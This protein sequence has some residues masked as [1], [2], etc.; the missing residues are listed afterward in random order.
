MTDEKLINL[1]SNTIRGLTLDA[2]D[3]AQSGHVGLPLGCADI[4]TILYNDILK[5]NPK[6]PKWLDRDRFV[7]SAGHGSMLL[8]SILYLTGYDITLEDIK[9]FRQLNSITPGH[10]EYGMTPGV[11]V[12]SGPLGQGVSNA[13]G[14]ALAERIMAGKYNTSKYEIIN[15]YT[16]C[17]AGDGCLMEGISSEAISFA[18]HLGLSKLILIYDDNKISIDGKTD[19]TFTE[20]IKKKF[21]AN[22]WHTQE[23]DAYDYKGFF[24]AVKHSKDNTNQP[25]IIIT[26]SIPGKGLEKHEGSHKSHGNPMSH[27]E[28]EQARKNFG[29]SNPFYIPEDVKEFYIK[30]SSD[31][32]EAYDKWEEIYSS[33][34]KENSDLAK[35][36]DLSKDGIINLVDNKFL[37]NEFGKKQATR[38]SSGE[39]INKIAD[40]VSFLVGGSADLASSNKVTIKS[41]G[42]I[43]KG[44]YNHRNI[45]FGVREHAMAGIINGINLHKGLRG[46]ASTFL[47]FSDYMRPAIRLASLM[48]IPSIFVFTHDSYQVGEDGPTHQPIEHVQSLRDI[49]NLI[50]IRPSDAK[51]VEEAWKYTINSKEP[52]ALILTRQKI[53]NIDRNKYSDASGLHKGAYII[54]ETNLDKID[55]IIISTGSEVFDAIKASEIMEQ[56]YSLG[57][58][59]VSMPSQEIFDKQDES[60][61]AMIFPS[62]VSKMVSIEAGVPYSWYRYI[63]KDGFAIGL[64]DFGKSA[65]GN[66]LEEFF[67]FSHG[68]IIKRIEKHFNLK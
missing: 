38:A 57:I 22:H 17:L 18:G 46:F 32:I 27:E 15:H 68:R 5:H 12:T 52:I 48:E 2:V 24:N 19:I 62:N 45:H 9:E 25:S 16:Y 53:E 47:V 7:L 44:D 55:M 50:V 60:Y 61:K 8:Y 23:V 54:K 3:K 43:S 10:P 6:Q 31:F 67:G 11:E 26:K 30:K 41:S 37:D 56:R 28:V 59:V 65:P 58:R 4:I 1:I 34:R 33:W 36:L 66:V 42:F 29:F 39:I 14:M 13:V 49:P 64:T 63:G 40:R 20:D 21:Q 35:V 51:E